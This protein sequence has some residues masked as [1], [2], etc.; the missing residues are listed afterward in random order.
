MKRASR[1]GLLLSS[2]L[3]WACQD[4]VTPAAQ[5][6]LD[7][8]H[9]ARMDASADRALDASV[10]AP[11]TAVVLA[12]LEAYPGQPAFC[13]RP[14]VDVV[15]DVFCTPSDPGIDNLR[16][17]ED[18]LGVNY[19][20]PG[21]DAARFASVELEPSTVVD[22]VVLLGHS[23][24]LS[25]RLASPLNP[26]AILIGQ[27]TFLTFQRGVQ[28]VEIAAYARDR[29]AFNFYLLSFRQACNERAGGCLPGDLYT[30]G[31]EQGWLH[32]T[33]RDDEE[34]KNTTSDCRQCH[35]RGRDTPVL[36]MRELEGPW[37]HFFGLDPKGAPSYPELGVTGRE[38]SQD[39]ARAKGDEPYAALPSNMFGHTVGFVL[40]NLVTAGQPLLFDAPG[41]DEELVYGVG[42]AGVSGRSPTWDRAF[43]A[44]KRGEQLALPYFQ[45]RPT[46]PAKQDRLTEAYQRYRRHELSAAALP[47]M[48]DIFPDDPQTRAEIGLQTEPLATPAEALVQA[49]G[50]CHNDVLDQTISRARFNIALARLDRAELDRAIERLERAGHEAGAMPPP[51]TRGLDPEGRARLIEY[52]RINLRSAEDDALLERAAVLGMNGGARL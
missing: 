37:T 16:T 11:D 23:T 47:D 43:A 29:N 21:V 22:V 13:L 51:E 27:Q 9:G 41:I 17:L 32:V 25:G 48:A 50:A 19:L 49:C 38:L 14:G 46:D 45:T 18:R 33:V 6:A 15:R 4:E 20:P 44:F 8:G 24:A 30:P 42:D 7:A 28:Q 39:Y 2:C 34:L 10:S 12:P 36:L 3:W 26:R 31:I 40:Q 1:V 5:T 35:Q 52:L